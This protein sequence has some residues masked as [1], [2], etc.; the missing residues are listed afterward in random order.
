MKKK[1]FWNAITILAFKDIFLYCM[2]NEWQRN[3]LNKFLYVHIECI[4]RNVQR[5]K[6]FRADI[7]WFEMAI[8]H[9]YLSKIRQR[10]EGR[11]I[12]VHWDA[13]VP[14]GQNRSARNE[15]YF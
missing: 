7:Q 1:Y 12:G 13:N 3:G 9:R 5:W 4:E 6:H 10:F 11:F 15:K 14:E 2:H 8:M